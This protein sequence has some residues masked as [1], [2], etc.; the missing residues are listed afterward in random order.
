MI[1]SIL[2]G[3]LASASV[4]S[5]EVLKLCRPALERKAGGEIQ[6]IGVTSTRKVRRGY[7]I[8][9]QMTVFIGMGPPQPGAASAHHLIRANFDFSCRT[10]GRN[11]RKTTVSQR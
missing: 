10:F 4:D 1:L 5:D 6:T 7:A 9:G 11:V 8:S 2:G 3:L